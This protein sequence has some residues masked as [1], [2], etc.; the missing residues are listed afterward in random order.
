MKTQYY[1][2]ILKKGI[3]PLALFIMI[4]IN[5]Q[6]SYSQ[7][8]DLAT[9]DE[10]ITQS[11]DHD[12]YIIDSSKDYINFP[13]KYKTV[14]P[15]KSYQPEAI[16]ENKDETLE[17]QD[18]DIY[19]NSIEYINNKAYIIMDMDSYI[20]LNEILQEKINTFTNSNQS[21][22]VSDYYINYIKVKTKANSKKVTLVLKYSNKGDIKK[23]IKR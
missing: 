20:A 22:N 16:A 8:N 9:N 17:L 21:L 6:L 14:E 13:V 2:Q 12:Y 4:I 23:I 10:V 15:L 11:N 1:I 19:D 18:K 3:A 5:I 7:A